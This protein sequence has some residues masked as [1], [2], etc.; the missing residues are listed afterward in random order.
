MVI[1]ATPVGGIRDL[2]E[3]Y[4]PELEDGCIVTDTG[5]TKAQ[6]LRWA[7]QYL[8]DRVNFVGGHP[9]AG[10]EISGPEGAQADLFKNATYCIIPG[11]TSSQK[12]VEA[13]VKMADT[14]EAKPYF[15]DPVEH[16]S[17]VASVSHRSEEHTSE[18]QSLVN[19]VCRLLLEKKK[20]TRL[21]IGKVTVGTHD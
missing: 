19:L 20:T 8:P 2:M 6:V 21:S 4:G 9:M 3:L 17:F 1:L 13:I 18:L 14:I 11:K 15:I 16:D 12:A 10:R 7:E 5:S